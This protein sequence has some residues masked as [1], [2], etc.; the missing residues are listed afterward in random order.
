LKIG[1]QDNIE[2]SYIV[3]TRDPHGSR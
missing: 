1:H 2:T 3:F